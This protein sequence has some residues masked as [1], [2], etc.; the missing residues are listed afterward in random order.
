MARN[1]QLRAA[2]RMPSTAAVVR[3][4]RRAIAPR[5][6]I[7]FAHGFM[8][9]LVAACA[10][11]L[12]A[13]TLQGP[14][15]APNA[16][17]EHAASVERAETAPGTGEAAVVPP[18]ATPDEDANKSEA[19]RVAAEMARREEARAAGLERLH[20]RGI[21]ELRTRDDKG[22]H[23]DQGDLDL[24]WSRELGLAASVSKLGDRWVWFGADRT[25]WWIFELK[26][27]PSSLR[28]GPIAGTRPGLA[29]ALPWLLGVRPLRP[30][31]GAVPEL[32]KLTWRV[33]VDVPQGVLPERAVLTAE[34]DPATLLPVATEL[35]LP[36]GTVWRS[37]FSEWLAVETPGAAEG[38]WPRV[39]RRVQAASGLDDRWTTVRVAL[40]TARADPEATDRPNLYDLALLRERF[41]PASVE[42]VP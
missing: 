13:C 28:T 31:G 11:L 38:A 26:A 4:V 8:P 6:A 33:K 34:F 40:D 21:M 18:Q 25:R 27:K 10:V 19:R 41:A 37:A 3:G 2:G 32:V 1:A 9:A 17:S 22:E 20:A 36:D 42:E 30:A 5:F 14:A 35:A 29:S 7:G 39:P 15:A 24:R 12:A 16:G 23:F